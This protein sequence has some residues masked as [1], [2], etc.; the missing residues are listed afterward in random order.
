MHEYFYTREHLTDGQ[1]AGSWN[2]ENPERVDIEGNQI[3]ITKEIK[4]G[5]SLDCRMF[6]NIDNDI[7]KVK[8]IFTSELT[9]EQKSQL[10]TI[11]Y[12]HKHNL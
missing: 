3:H 4:D 11:V 5:L 9:P 2:I 10:D 7:S 1:Y 6:C 12:N 8:F